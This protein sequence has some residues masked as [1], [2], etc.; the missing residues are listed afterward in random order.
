MKKK[1]G[2]SFAF[3]CKEEIAS[4][5]FS[6][7]EIRPFLSA[8][9]RQN[10]SFRM[11]GGVDELD[12]SCES[13]KV[14]KLIYEL[15]KR[16]YGISARFSY[17]RS[18]GFYKKMKYH[19][20]FSSPETIMDDLEIAFLERIRP[21]EVV[22]SVSH[23][24]AFL[25]GA[26]CASGSVN[27]PSSSNYHL[28][29]T[30]Y[31]ERDA[32][33]LLHIF[34]KANGGQFHPRL[35]KRR[36][37]FVVYI[38]KAEEIADFLIAIGATQCCLKFEDVRVSRDFSNIGNR[39]EILDRANLDKSMSA[40]RMQALYIEDYLSRVGMERIKNQ[41]LKLLIQLRMDNEEASM[42]ELAHL[43]SEE[44]AM[45]VTKSNVNHLF[46]FLKQ[47]YEAHHGKDKIR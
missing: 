13:A 28:E 39:L 6:D 29:I 20:L 35:I 34:A 23:Y 3:L 5:D 42:E 38:K 19:V 43:M 44:L 47:E 33:W 14:A 16:R 1:E 7:D 11:A 30:H 40:S 45:T 37:Q 18:M 26:F 41:K 25:M 4:R 46:R 24:P 10:G 32:K 22:K 21:N 8:F 12:F 9:C 36:N 17:S 31:D 15:G 27:D 2:P